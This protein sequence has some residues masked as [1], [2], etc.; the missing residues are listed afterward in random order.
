MKP[1]QI[2]HG[3]VCIIIHKYCINIH[4]KTFCIYKFSFLIP[5]TAAAFCDIII[6]Q[7]RDRDSDDA[8]P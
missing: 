4:L 7:N 5:F 1:R 2:E 6:L 8:D 3:G